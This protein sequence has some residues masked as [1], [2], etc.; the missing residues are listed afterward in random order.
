MLPFVDRNGNP[1]PA[2]KAQLKSDE[3]RIITL[4]TVIFS[5]DGNTYF[6]LVPLGGTNAAQIPYV[7]YGLSQGSTVVDSSQNYTLGPDLP[8][9]F[10][11]PAG[12]DLWAGAFGF[13]ALGIAGDLNPADFVMRLSLTVAPAESARALDRLIHGLGRVVEQAL[14]RAFAAHQNGR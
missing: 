8:T 7:V 9:Q 12:E 14:Q 2:Q 10:M 6:R 4:N 13:P 5:A 3:D 11:L 1:P